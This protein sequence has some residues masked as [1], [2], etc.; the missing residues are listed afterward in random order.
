MGRATRPRPSRL[1]AKLAEIRKKLNLSQNGMIMHMGLE[2]K[3]TQAEISAFERGIRQPPLYVLLEY[4]RAAA[5]TRKAG[6]G[7]GD[8]LEILVDD[9]LSLPKELP[10]TLKRRGAA[11]SRK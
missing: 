1:A 10:D 9:S 11:T 4:A 2:N 3:L 7:T 5:G 8:Y 6:R